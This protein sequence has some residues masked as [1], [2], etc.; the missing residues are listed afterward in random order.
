M[1]KKTTVGK[2]IRKGWDPTGLHVTMETFHDG[3]VRQFIGTVK[4]TRTISVLDIFDNVVG[5]EQRLVVH[6]FN[7]EP[8]PFNPFPAQCEVI[9]RD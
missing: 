9:K 1:A 6:Y 5:W 3:E 7:G 2:Y 8:W 4:D